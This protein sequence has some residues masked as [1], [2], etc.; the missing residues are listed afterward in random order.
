MLWGHP[1]QGENVN[2]IAPHSDHKLDGLTKW[3][4]REL[5]PIYARFT[6]PLTNRKPIPK[7]EPEQPDC[8]R[9][10]QRRMTDYYLSAFHG[11]GILAKRQKILKGRN[12]PQYLGFPIRVTSVT[13]YQYPTHP[14]QFRTFKFLFLVDLRKFPH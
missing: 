14:L 12:T 7:D 9:S 8:E 10:E 3:V 2:L 13:S 11:L 6:A 1:T 5:I 4:V